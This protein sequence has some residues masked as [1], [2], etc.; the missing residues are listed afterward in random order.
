MHV[1]VCCVCVC[2]YAFMRVVRAD[3]K[4]GVRT[5]VCECVHAYVCV[6]VFAYDVYDVA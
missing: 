5:Y 6:C 3:C 2:R 4:V 1:S